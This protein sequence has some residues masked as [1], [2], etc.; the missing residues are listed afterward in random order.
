MMNISLKTS[1]AL[2]LVLHAV[3]ATSQTLTGKVLDA[4]TKDP[5]PYANVVV[6]ATNAGTITNE[7]GEFSIG[8]LNSN[9]TIVV[10][11][12]GFKT[13][14]EKVSNL[15]NPAT[16]YLKEYT[17]E[18]SEVSVSSKKL[19][20]NDLLKS[21]R[22]IRDSLY[23]SNTEVTNFEYNRFL[24]FNGT[25]DGRDFDLSGYRSADEAYFKRYQSRG[26][27]TGRQRN[28]STANY[29]HYPAVNVTY[30][31]AVAYCEWLTDEYNN[32]PGR[33]R[34]KKVKF[35]LPSLNEWRIAAL[36]NED[37]QS[38]IPE[39]NFVMVSISRDTLIEVV[40]RKKK[41]EKLWIKDEVWY[42]WWGSYHYRKKAQNHLNFFLGNFKEPVSYKPCISPKG[43]PKGFK[44]PPF[45]DGWSRM[46]QT[47][48]YFPNNIG[49]YDVVGN[50]AEMIDEKGK[51]CGGS[52]NSYPSDATIWTVDTYTKASGEVGFR[53]FMEIVE[54]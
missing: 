14:V 18:L 30:E 25:H 1:V 4:K 2:L 35:R 24:Y 42:P 46:S 32:S 20:P 13:I 17:V 7:A 36:G 50:V 9:D 33:K 15:R 26:K 19:N 40:D 44:C 3:T 29:N 37:F 6:F 31:G 8:N 53:V 28:D 52:W 21:M 23:A 45:G 41:K 22:V 39:E 12:L 10:S 51:A 38:W 43:S 47:A 48:S 34:Y 11:Y 54:K 5:L 49:L 16:I 27:E